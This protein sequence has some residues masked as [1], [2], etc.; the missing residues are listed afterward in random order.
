M[1]RV[2]TKKYDFWLKKRGKFNCLVPHIQDEHDKYSLANSS[3]LEDNT[4]I[5]YYPTW[6]QFFVSNSFEIEKSD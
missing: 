6:N 5:N 1:G 4:R 2:E 3:I